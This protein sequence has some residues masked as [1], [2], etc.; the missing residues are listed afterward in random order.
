MAI[1]NNEIL[2]DPQL[3]DVGIVQASNA[4]LFLKNNYPFILM[5]SVFC[6]SILLR[7][8]ETMSLIL[9]EL[10]IFGTSNIINF[11]N[12]NTINQ[13]IYVL[14]SSHEISNFIMPEKFVIKTGQCTNKITNRL[15]YKCD[16]ITHDDG[17]HNFNWDYYSK[18]KNNNSSKHINMIYESYLICAYLLK[19][20]DDYVNSLR[21]MFENQ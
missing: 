12:S 9:K 2:K 13:Q 4:G 5:N 1:N 7:T 8:R 21:L 20:D 17:I 3:T 11:G 19:K 14:P 6:C 18:Y 15:L 16:F 10:N